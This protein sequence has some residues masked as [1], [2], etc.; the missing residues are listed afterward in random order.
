MG[1]MIGEHI[2][3]RRLEKRLSLS[4]LAQTANVSKTYLSTLER[5]IQKNPS[6]DIVKKI[7]DVL[8]INPTLLINGLD[9]EEKQSIEENTYPTIE[10]IFHFKKYIEE[11]DTRQLENL[12]EF[13]DFTLWKRR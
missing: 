1:K 3:N 9:E 7:A 12:R 6:L 2:R 11:L 4:E 10:S 13:I 5:N 8:E